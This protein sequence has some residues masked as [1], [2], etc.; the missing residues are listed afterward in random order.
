MNRWLWNVKRPA[1]IR[2]WGKPRRPYRTKRW[3]PIYRLTRRR[4]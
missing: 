1:R 2:L 3:L 4:L